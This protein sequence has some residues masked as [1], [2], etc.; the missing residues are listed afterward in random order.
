MNSVIKELWHGNIVPQDDSRNNSP[1]MKELMEYMARHHEILLKS[2]TDEQKDILEEGLQMRKM[3]DLAKTAA[4]H[5]RIEDHK[6]QCDEG[7]ER[8]KSNGRD[9]R[10]ASEYS[11]HEG[12]SDHSLQKSQSHSQRS[13]PL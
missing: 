7:E 2:V 8:L 13:L 1:E 12:S 6:N 11:C 4:V 3:Y 9:G 5:L 10:Q